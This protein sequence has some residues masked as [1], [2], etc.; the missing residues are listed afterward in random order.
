[1][2]SRLNKIFKFFLERPI[3]SLGLMFGLWVNSLPLSDAK[4]V[5]KKKKIWY[6]FSSSIRA[7]FSRLELADSLS[8]KSRKIL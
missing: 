8:K 1:M 3:L 2:K 7:A 5:S 4:I 6:R